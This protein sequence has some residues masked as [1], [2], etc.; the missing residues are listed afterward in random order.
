MDIKLGR[1]PK[2]SPPSHKESPSSQKNLMP[3]LIIKSHGAEKVAVGPETKVSFVE[4]GNVGNVKK[5]SPQS[6]GKVAV[7]LREVCA[8]PNS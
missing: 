6:I 1:S 3:R 2:N 8:K 4:P 5:K 7:E